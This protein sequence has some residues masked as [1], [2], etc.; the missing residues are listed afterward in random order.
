M[1]LIIVNYKILEHPFPTE[2]ER[3]VYAEISAKIV[4]PDNDVLIKLTDTKWDVLQYFNWFVE[5]SEELLNQDVPEFLPKGHSIAER[6]RKFLDLVDDDTK[7][8]QISDNGYDTLHYHYTY[9]HLYFNSVAGSGNSKVSF[10]REIYIG[11]NNDKYEISMFS[12]PHRFN[13]FKEMHWKY[14]IDLPAFINFARKQY[15]KIINNPLGHNK[16]NVKMFF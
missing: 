16:Y 1:N 6:N 3:T 12:E 5:N 10:P 7:W 13:N 11:R 15:E 14:E 4:S 8:N 9:S 2:K